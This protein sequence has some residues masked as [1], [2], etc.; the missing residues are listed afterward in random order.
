MKLVNLSPSKFVLF[1]ALA[2]ALVLPLA[3]TAEE[4]LPLRMLANAGINTGGYTTLFDI[5]ISEWTSDAERQQVLDALKND[6]SLSMRQSLQGFD[7][8]GRIA[9]RAQ[10]GVDLRY[11]YKFEE[12]NGT[13]IVLV[14]DRPVDVDEAIAQGI[15]SRSYNTTVVVIELDEQG[16]G[17]GTLMLAAEVKFGA[18]GRLAFTSVT[19]AKVNLGN[20]RVAGR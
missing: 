8:K 9:A 11:A 6:G 4:E 2:V 12:A 15:T 18:D 16:K 5:T 1:L 7:S 19:P 10:L 14:T 17:A 3:A 13:T 20:V